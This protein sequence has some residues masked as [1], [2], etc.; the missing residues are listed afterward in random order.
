MFVV[1]LGVPNNAL[2]LGV[3][4]TISLVVWISPRLFSLKT[5]TV[6]SIRVRSPHIWEYGQDLAE[7]YLYDDP[8]ASTSSIK[9][10]VEIESRWVDVEDQEQYPNAEVN[11]GSLE[12]EQEDMPAE[13]EEEIPISNQWLYDG[14]PHLI[15]FT[16]V[17][18]WS[19]PSRVP[20]QG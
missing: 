20:I 15:R 1:L 5:N 14:S 13:E 6:Q 12:L 11:L 10:A 16:K 9:E 3:L 7:N 8:N 18:L 19:W 4:L 2:V 17:Y